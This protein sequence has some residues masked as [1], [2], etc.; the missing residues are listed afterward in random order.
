M[1]GHFTWWKCFKLILMFYSVKAWVSKRKCSSTVHKL[2]LDPMMHACI[3][4]ARE[5]NNSKFIWDGIFIG[6]VYF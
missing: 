1:H 5:K 2:L 3:V 4:S 6:S